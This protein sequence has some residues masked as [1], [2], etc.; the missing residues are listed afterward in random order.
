MLSVRLTYGAC[1]AN[2]LIAGASLRDQ[3]YAHRL[4]G[5]DDVVEKALARLEALSGPVFA[6]VRGAASL[7]GGGTPE[8]ENLLTF[9][10]F[11]FARTPCGALHD[12]AA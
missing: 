11:Q 2:R 5:A 10:G 6:A 8:R 1:S 7:P 12:P 4:Y 3:C 9:I